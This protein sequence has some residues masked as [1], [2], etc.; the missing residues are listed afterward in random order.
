MS[1][2]VEN[3]VAIVT[4]AASGQGLEEAKLL[5]KEGAKVVA[6]DLNYEGAE[7]VVAEIKKAGGSAVAVKHDVANEDDW[8]NVVKTSLDEYG[9]IDVLVNNAGIGGVEG[10]ALIDDVD[11]NGWNKFM[12][13]NATSQFL[14]IK[15]VIDEMRKVGGG[16][17]INISSMAGLVGGAA[18]IHYTASKGAIRLLSKDAAV[19]LGPDNI[20]VN[21]IHPGFID[22]PMVSNVT[23][24]EAATAA[25]VSGIP[26]GRVAKPVEV[27][28]VVLFLA[29]DDSSYITGA[30]IPVDGG[31]T[32]K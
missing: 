24:D 22:T 5:A 6:T 32:A 15:A 17:I 18:G 21:S 9:R 25:A 16:S 8:K 26:M 2:R 27:A 1:G 3:K 7:E 28:S 20:R 23:S 30:E 19:E 11:L 10:F 13:V 29:S 4:G 14:G 12:T 31:A